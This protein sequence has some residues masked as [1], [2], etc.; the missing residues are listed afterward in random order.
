[1]RES[2]FE[3]LDLNHDGEISRSELHKAA[4]L[5]GWHWYE[6]PIFALFDLLALSGPISKDQFNGYLLQIS[7][8]PLGP[9]GKV[10]LNSGH[11]CSE[12]ASMPDQPISRSRAGAD[13]K[14]KNSRKQPEDQWASNPSSVLSKTSGID[15]AIYFGRVLDGLESCRLSGSGTALLIIDTQRSFT[16]GA[17][18]QSIGDGAETDVEPIVTAFDNC[19]KLLENI[20]RHVEIMFTRCPFPPASYDWHDGLAEIIDPNQLYIIKPGN[21]VLFPA[22][23]GFHKWMTR[24]LNRG[25]KALVIGG[26]TLNSC[27]RISSMETLAEYK[28]RGLCVY[29]DLSIC[30]ARARNFKPSPLYNGMSAAESAIRQMTDAGVQVVRRVRWEQ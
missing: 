24:C 17:W 8:D 12:A 3:I 19:A 6:A 4:E 13:A 9:Y 30:G 18:M 16:S 7:E 23:N 5:L 2:L 26:C 10:L 21:S 14:S 20:Y 22:C 28:D 27:V 25:K 1:M 29:V 11:Y 15:N